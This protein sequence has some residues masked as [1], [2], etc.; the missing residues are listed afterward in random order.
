MSLKTVNQVE[1]TDA[2]GEVDD[3]PI[4]ERNSTLNLYSI[5]KS[6]IRDFRFRGD[7]QTFL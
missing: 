1:R 2:W 3:V 5:L 7:R 6:I 4:G